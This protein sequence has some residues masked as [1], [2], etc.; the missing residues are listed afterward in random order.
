M[1]T[2]EDAKKKL[3][4]LFPLKEYVNNFVFISTCY[5]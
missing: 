3:K 5:N 1:E 2:K 4:Q